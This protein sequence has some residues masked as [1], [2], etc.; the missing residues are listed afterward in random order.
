MCETTL[1]SL[2]AFAMSAVKT[3]IPALFAST[4]A[5][6]IACESYGVRTIALD[7][8]RDEVLDLALLLGVVAGR[9]DDVD[10]V[11]VLGGLGLHPGSMS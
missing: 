4:I 3:G 2:D 10:R 6:P 11:A 9:V 7:L 5:L 1:P 8:L